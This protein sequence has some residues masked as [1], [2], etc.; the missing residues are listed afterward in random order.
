MIILATTQTPCPKSTVVQ[1]QK[2]ERQEFGR[3]LQTL[4]V[5]GWANTQK[6]SVHRDQLTNPL[7]FHD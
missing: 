1:W 7:A 3:F 5:A 6:W 2:L 4:G